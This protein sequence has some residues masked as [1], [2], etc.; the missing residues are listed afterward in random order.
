MTNSADFFRNLL[1]ALLPN[2]AAPVLA[3]VIKAHEGPGKNTYS[4]DVR[5][6]TLGTLED[7]DHLIAEVPL[8]PIWA[9]QK[10]RGVYAIP[11]EGQVVIV[12]FL[13]WNPAYPFVA[14]IWSD[15]YEAGEFGKDRFVIADGG[16]MEFTIDANEKGI[17]I[18]NGKVQITLKGDKCA[19]KNGSQSLFAILDTLLS[20]L[21]AMKTVGSPAMHTVDPGDIAKLQQD[22][23]A[24]AALLED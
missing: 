9:G 20:N 12:E 8:S 15:E 18:N 14:G 3:R 5:V 16:G 22:A 10:K 21:A 1:N 13:G 2:R 6:V 17:A 23:A 4:V 24:L 19:I 7:T 11:N